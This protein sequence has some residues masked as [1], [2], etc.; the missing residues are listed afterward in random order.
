MTLCCPANN[1]LEQSPTYGKNVQHSANLM[2]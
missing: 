1:L 2:A